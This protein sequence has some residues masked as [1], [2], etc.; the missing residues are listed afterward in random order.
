[1]FKVWMLNF[2]LEYVIFVLGCYILVVELIYISLYVVA[3]CVAPVLR[4]DATK[5]IVDRS[6][7]QLLWWHIR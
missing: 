6:S 2:L 5:I 1:M 7:F 3:F 4:E